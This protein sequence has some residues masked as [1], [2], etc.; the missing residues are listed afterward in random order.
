MAP[1]HSVLPAGALVAANHRRTGAPKP[2]DP[3]AG[4]LVRDVRRF[5]NKLFPAAL[6]ALNDIMQLSPLMQVPG[7]TAALEKP[8]GVNLPWQFSDTTGHR[9]RVLHGITDLACTRG[10]GAHSGPWSCP[11]AQ[12]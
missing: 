4:Q 1:C 3:L 12:R 5:I 6:T 8:S 7:Y 2:A 9:L 11:H 10:L